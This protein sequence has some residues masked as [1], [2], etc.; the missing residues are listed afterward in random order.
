[1]CSKARLTK[2]RYRR[3]L[4]WPPMVSN[5]VLL[6]AST[7]CLQ[8]V[9]VNAQCTCRAYLLLRMDQPQ[10]CWRSCKQ[11]TPADGW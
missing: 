4:H 7:P 2:V 10:R 5:G 3:R 6:M 1:M 9:P 8:R 11:D